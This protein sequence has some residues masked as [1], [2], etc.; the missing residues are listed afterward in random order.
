MTRSSLATALLPAI[1]T[2][3]G[4]S[5]PTCLLHKACCWHTRITTIR[6][7]WTKPSFAVSQAGTCGSCHDAP[8]TV[9]H[10]LLHNGRNRFIS[11]NGYTDRLSPQPRTRHAQKQPRQHLP[12]QGRAWVA[13]E[14]SH[15]DRLPSEAKHT[16]HPHTAML[17]SPQR[18]QIRVD[19]KWL[20][21][22][23]QTGM[24]VR[25][26]TPC[27]TTVHTTQRRPGH[28]L[29]RGAFL[30]FSPSFLPRMPAP[31]CAT[32]GINHLVSTAQLLC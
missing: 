10:K 32:P 14:N 5:Q 6:H 8:L 28:N 30:I 24:P 19:R 2:I 27:D 12:R 13:A 26:T 1:Q 20:S 11:G 15:A 25:S 29:C 21:T 18:S 23:E 16:P 3:L 17:P 4:I 7:R 31:P 9:S 22:Q